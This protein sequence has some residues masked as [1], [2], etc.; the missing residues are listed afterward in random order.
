MPYVQQGNKL[1]LA[2]DDSADSLVH[3][4][5]KNMHWGERLYQNKDGSLTALGKIHYGYQNTKRR[6]AA[7]AR[8][9]TRAANAKA[10]AKAEEKALKEQEKQMKELKKASKKIKNEASKNSEKSV[11]IDEASADYILSRV[12]S[13]KMSNAELQAAVNR[14]RN[15]QELKKFLAPKQ[16]L[17][18]KIFKESSEKFVKAASN[19][20]AEQAGKHLANTILKKMNIPVTNNNN[21]KN[22][23]NNNDE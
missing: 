7:K 8:A 4:G 20:L 5:T 17:G 21:K 10:A 9:K 1:Y 11:N 13:H 15:E 23:N 19:Q 2:T 6:K 3:H 12:S 14:M 16:T 22:K 18:E